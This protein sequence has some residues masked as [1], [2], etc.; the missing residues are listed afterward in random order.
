MQHPT[1]AIAAAAITNLLEGKTAH[2]EGELGHA[3]AFSKLAQDREAVI[4][5][6][7]ALCMNLGDPYLAFHT[8]LGERLLE[9][10]SAQT[11]LSPAETAR[12][13]PVQALVDVIRA[14]PSSLIRA[15]SI[16]SLLDQQQPG[17][18]RQ[19]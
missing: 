15:P 17:S 9:H 1:R 12:S 6:L 13:L 7:H 19:A 10:V 2:G 5:V 8:D 14:R 16:A 4:D 11:G 18:P 3:L